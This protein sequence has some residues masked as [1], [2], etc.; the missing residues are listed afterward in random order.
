MTSLVDK[1]KTVTG[2]KEDRLTDS[3]SSRIGSIEDLQA[4]TNL[5]TTTRAPGPK[6]APTRLKTEA[7]TR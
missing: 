7:V 5:R 3:D 4:K 2:I 1:A 6:T